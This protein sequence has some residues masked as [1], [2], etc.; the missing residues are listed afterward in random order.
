MHV[1]TLACA[2]ALV[3]LAPA[4]ALPAFA[5]QTQSNK[6]LPAPAVLRV[7]TTYGGNAGAAPRSPVAQSTQ[8]LQAQV[9]AQRY[10]AAMAFNQKYGPGKPVRLKTVSARYR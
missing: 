10:A 5:Q 9:Q 8:A 7:P 2:A 4:F 6:A 3:A 1:R